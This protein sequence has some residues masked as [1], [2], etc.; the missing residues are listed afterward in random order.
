VALASL[1]LVIG[2][3]PAFAGFSVSTAPQSMTVSSGTLSPPS[4]LSATTACATA[5]TFRSATSAALLSV[6]SITINTPSGVTTN[7][8]L[9]A[10]IGYHRD[11]TQ[12]SITAPSGWTLARA[13]SWTGQ[14]WTQSI[15]YHVVTGTEP[16][17]Y[18][19]TVS[20][21]DQ[22]A[23]TIVA[24]SGVDTANPINANAGQ[25][26][27]QG[28][29]I[30]AP[31]VTPTSNNSVLLW[32]YGIKS[33]GTIT[34]AAGQTTRASASTATGNPT[35]NNADIIVAEESQ[36]TAAATGTRTATL[37]GNSQYSTGSVVALTRD[38]GSR[39]GLTWTATPTASAAGYTLTRTGPTGTSVYTIS[40]ASTTSVVNGGLTSGASYTYSLNAFVGG[41]TSSAVTT[42]VTAC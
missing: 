39:A 42:T 5:I 22:L 30:S 31:S 18:T 4:G 14:M 25:N 34:P 19:W 33:V 12:A 24:Y 17:G 3:I 16:A 6:T 21:A 40:P 1:A 9:I 8:V 13:D 28:T 27:N 20:V 26:N 35:S 32:F 23:G 37:S 11:A 15:Y 41:W 10:Q 36:T 29:S 7:D 38:T 2:Q